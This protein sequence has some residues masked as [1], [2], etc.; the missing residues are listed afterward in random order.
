MPPHAHL[1]A[2]DRWHLVDRVKR[3]AR[4]AVDGDG[5]GFKAFDRW[6]REPVA[7]PEPPAPS[8]DRVARGRMLLEKMECI[9]CHG[10]EWRGLTRTERGFDWA[11]EAGRPIPRSAD[12]VRGLFKS[13]S[14]PKDLYRTIFLGRAG[15]PMPS[16]GS[17][18][19]SDEDR[20]AI[21]E[22]VRSLRETRVR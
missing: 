11:D 10:A 17:I 13:G 4:I 16:Y 2:Q 19:H 18:F 21:V 7:I 6:P 1:P 8:P 14:S 12:L 15:T 20:W 3:F 5:D 9:T 22:Y